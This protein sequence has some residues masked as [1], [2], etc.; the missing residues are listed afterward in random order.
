MGG[1]GCASGAGALIEVEVRDGFGFGQVVSGRLVEVEAGI[2]VEGEV[3][4]GRSAGGSEGRRVVG[5][6]RWV[7]MASTG[8]AAVMKARMRMS[9]PQS[10]Q[11]R[12]K[13]S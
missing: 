6:P 9:P 4:L 2:G 5:R 1:R 10:G 3:V 11:V 7:R 13:T 8:S 12:G